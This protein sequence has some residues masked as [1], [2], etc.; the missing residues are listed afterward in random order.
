MWDDP[1]EMDMVVTI[2]QQPQL[3]EHG[4]DMQSRENYRRLAFKSS[5]KCIL[6]WEM[7]EW[8]L[9]CLLNALSDVRL[10]KNE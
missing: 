9:K 3:L 10:C 6:Y 5:R 7:K 2:T 4:C 8:M 1:K